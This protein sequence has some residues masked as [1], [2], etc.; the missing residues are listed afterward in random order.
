MCTNI[1]FYLTQITHTLLGLIIS[2][3]PL[4]KCIKLCSA[5]LSHLSDVIYQCYPISRLPSDV[6]CTDTHAVM[7]HALTHMPWCVMHWHTCC[8]VS[9]TDTH[10]VYV[11]HRHTCRLRH[12]LTYM[13]WWVMHWH[14]CSD[15]HLKFIRLNYKFLFYKRSNYAE[16]FRVINHKNLSPWVQSTASN[17]LTA[18]TML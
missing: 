4:V 5:A 2:K 9:C 1:F 11:M 10:A 3:I 12:A 8:D 15:S 13:P 16:S 7:C 6:S 17:S 14:A 18:L